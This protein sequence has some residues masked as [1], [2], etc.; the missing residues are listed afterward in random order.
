MRAQTPPRSRAESRRLPL[1]RWGLE[2]VSHQHEQLALEDIPRSAH[3]AA[4]SRTQHGIDRC[5][6]C[7]SRRLADRSAQR[8][9]EL[10]RPDRCRR[11]H[12]QQILS[13][14]SHGDP[15]AGRSPPLTRGQGGAV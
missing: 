6:R 1:P 13:T 2:A 9:L 11:S 7:G 14:G 15:V 10:E 3:R 5:R 12:R 4:D 8:L